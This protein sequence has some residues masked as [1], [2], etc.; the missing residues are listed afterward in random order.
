MTAARASVSTARRGAR[1]PGRKGAFPPGPRGAPWLGVA[2]AF[3]YD[4]LR[5]MTEWVRRFGDVVHYTVAGTHIYVLA[6]PE[7]IAQVL[8]GDHQHTMKD[9]LT[10]ALASF[11]GRGL[12]TSEG[13]YWR[14]QRRII[15]PTF[16]PRHIERFADAMV[17]RTRTRLSGLGSGVRDVH[18]DFM[19]LTLAIVLDTLF[20][21]AEVPD[22]GAVER[23]VG[24]MMDASRSTFSP[25]GGCCRSGSTPSR[26]RACRGPRTSST[27]SC[28]A[29]SPS[30]AARARSATTCSAA[31]SRPATRTA[32]A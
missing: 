3:Q 8:V 2:I 17:H 26:S 10:H 7:D 12:L 15:A 14:R 9:E 20:G 31:C 19:E 5:R 11:V 18:R 30:A 1:G 21:A 16:Q 28:F 27:P 24:T 29:S 25:G 6:H 4:P 13:S 32:A 23:I 22:L